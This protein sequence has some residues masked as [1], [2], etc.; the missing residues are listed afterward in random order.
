MENWFFFIM[1]F[2]TSYDFLGSYQPI[3]TYLG[4]SALPSITS[5]SF[6]VLEGLP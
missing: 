5:L 2:R 1:L 6:S 4:V 3:V